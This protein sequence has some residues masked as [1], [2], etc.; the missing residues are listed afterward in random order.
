M[1]RCVYLLLVVLFAGGVFACSDED[2]SV[3]YLK[4]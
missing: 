3:Y 4:R 2:D 1:K